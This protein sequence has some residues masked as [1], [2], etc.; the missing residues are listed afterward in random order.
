L[1]AL[2]A[3]LASQSHWTHNHTAQ[4]N[5]VWQPLQRASVDVARAKADMQAQE[6]SR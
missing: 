5:P 6:L 2:E 3:L 1:E 4:I